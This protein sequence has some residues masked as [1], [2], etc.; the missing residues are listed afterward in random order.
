MRSAVLI[1]DEVYGSEDELQRATQ[2]HNRTQG[3]ERARGTKTPHPQLA[4]SLVAMLVAARGIQGVP[5]GLLGRIDSI[6]SW[7]R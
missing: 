5:R 1:T 3:Y 2:A 4:S 6:S 7:F